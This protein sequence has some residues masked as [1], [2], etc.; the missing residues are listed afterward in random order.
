MTFAKQFNPFTGELD[1]YA[2]SN[3]EGTEWYFVENGY[4]LEL[5]WKSTLVH[6][7]SVDAPTIGV[8]QPMG[9]LLTLTYAS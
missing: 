6:S 8:G 7:W 4:T 5:W 3:G 1:Y 9:L 2:T